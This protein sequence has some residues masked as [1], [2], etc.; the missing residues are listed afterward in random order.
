MLPVSKLIYIYMSTK[1]VQKKK[2][3]NERRKNHN[4]QKKRANNSTDFVMFRKSLKSYG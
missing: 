3:K 4:Y 1:K 2:K